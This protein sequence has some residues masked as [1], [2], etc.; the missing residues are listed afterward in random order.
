MNHEALRSNVFRT[1]LVTLCIALCHGVTYA[2]PRSSDVS[3]ELIIDKQLDT[4]DTKLTAPKKTTKKKTSTTH[5]PQQAEHLNILYAAWKQELEMLLS[6]IQHI[7]QLMYTNKIVPTDLHEAGAWLQQ[8]SGIISKTMKLPYAP[9]T[10]HKLLRFF[11]FNK[12]LTKALNRAFNNNFSTLPEIHELEES[13]NIL[14]KALKT[15]SKGAVP[16]ETLSGY[17]EEARRSATALTNKIARSGLTWYNH[18]YRALLSINRQLY[19]TSL[20]QAVAMGA[21]FSG[22]FMLAFGKQGTGDDLKWKDVPL[23]GP[24]NKLIQNNLGCWAKY[25]SPGSDEYNR[26]L[27]A[28]SLWS[29]LIGIYNAGFF[30][31]LRDGLGELDAFLKGTTYDSGRNSIQYV[32]NHITLED[33]KFNSVRHLFGPFENIRR[34]FLSPDLYIHAGIKVPRCILMTGVPGCGKT[35]CMYAFA[36]SLTQDMMLAGMPHKTAIIEITSFDIQRIE[37]IIATAKQ[38]APCIILLDELHVIGGGVQINSNAVLLNVLLIEIDKIDKSNDPTQQI[39]IIAATNRPDLLARALL[40]HG[41][42]G[43]DSRIDFPMPNFTQ[44]RSVIDALCKRSAVD[45]STID[46]D[47]FA[48]LT[49]GTSFSAINKIFEKAGFLAKEQATGITS[50]HLYEGVNCALRS[51]NPMVGLNELEQEIVAVHMAGIALAH[52]LIDTQ[53]VLDAITIKMPARKIHEQLDFMAKMENQDEDKQ[54]TAHYGAFYTYKLNEHITIESSDPFAQCKLLLAG[55]TAQKVILGRKSSYG[56]DDRALAFEEAQFAVLDGLKLDKLGKSGKNSFQSNAYD[57]LVA[58]E[59]ELIKLF[60][61][62]ASSIRLIAD[63]LKTKLLL[64]APEIK[65]LMRRAQDEQKRQPAE[66]TTTFE[67]AAAL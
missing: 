17:A 59:I 2:P 45:T 37:E 39:F 16:L 11:T 48:H 55:V 4:I 52:M 60:Q 53:D 13:F 42:F 14:V 67:P 34:Y 43:P 66:L 62:H 35:E 57:A 51:L 40:R 8:L 27:M 50:D 26:T 56:K 20:A 63:E 31:A 30:G 15:P 64:T 33:P 54:H 24:T 23:V 6:S 25:W 58:C 28:M 5:T 44:R 3:D 12:E 29:G 65:A 7:A 61:E 18:F 41:R 1:F 10:P 9:L 21:V 46:L 32:D 19:I 49:Q 47:Y 22:L 36:G 38:N